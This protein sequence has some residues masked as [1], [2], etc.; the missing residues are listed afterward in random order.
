L[1]DPILDYFKVRT[2]IDLSA[3]YPQVNGSEALIDGILLNLV[4]NSINAFQRRTSIQ[5][6]KLRISTQ[7][8]GDVLLMVEDNAGGIDGFD[9]QEIFMPGVTSSPDGTG[10]G[11]TI[12]QDSVSDLGGRIDVD[13]KSGFGGALFTVRLPPMRTLFR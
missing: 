8:D 9:V 7:Y 6:R 5:E 13:P 4:T 3:S 11:L 10:F 1:T 12:V 2:E